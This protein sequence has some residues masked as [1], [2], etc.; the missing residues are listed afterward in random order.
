MRTC[1]RVG[2][3]RPGG[4][5]GRAEVA[6]AKSRVT[7]RPL[8]VGRSRRGQRG[9]RVRRGDVPLR[10]W[11]L[12][13]TAEASQGSRPADYAASHARTRA[14]TFRNR[15]SS[16]ERRTRRAKHD[17]RHVRRRARAFERR[18]R[19]PEPGSRTLERRTSTPEQASRN[20]EHPA[21]AFELRTRKFELRAQ[22]TVLG[23]RNAKLHA[24]TPG[25]GTRSPASNARAVEQRTP[26]PRMRARAP[27]YITWPKGRARQR[28]GAQGRDAP[29]TASSHPLRSW[30]QMCKP[31][32]PCR[33]HVA[34]RC[35]MARSPRSTQQ[36]KARWKSA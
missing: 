6:G 36:L 30:F 13:R 22:H 21:R 17:A 1:R 11:A 16:A 5:H 2:P 20:I 14:R 25:P 15:A 8:A 3:R 9:G 7:V 35:G 32:H 29:G 33:R 31:L 12:H 19:R 27:A 28:P 26:T 24:H 23:T 34:R 4:R 18:T 10:P